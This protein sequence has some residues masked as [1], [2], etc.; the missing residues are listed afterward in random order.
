MQAAELKEVKHGNE[1]GLKRVTTSD[2]LIL[3][4][5]LE[6]MVWWMFGTLVVLNLCFACFILARRLGPQYYGAGRWARTRDLEVTLHRYCES[7]DPALLNGISGLSGWLL[8]KA[9][10]WLHENRH[11]INAARRAELLFATG[12]AGTYAARAYGRRSAQQVLL[13]AGLPVVVI[14]PSI[15]R[16]K[17]Y[18]RPRPCSVVRTHAVGELANLPGHAGMVFALAAMTDTSPEVRRQAVLALGRTGHPGVLPILWMELQNHQ[19]ESNNTAHVE[20]ALATF[21]PRA[22]S[23]F[24]PML[25]SHDA[26]VRE[27]AAQAIAR[28]GQRAVSAGSNADFPIEVADILKRSMMRD[29]SMKVRAHAIAAAPHLPRVTATNLLRQLLTDESEIVRAEAAFACARGD[30]LELIPDLIRSSQDP[31]WQVRTAAVAALVELGNDAEAALCAAFLASID[32]YACDELAEGIQRSGL[33]RRLVSAFSNGE[34]FAVCAETVFR[35]MI[36][37]GKTCALDA[38]AG[39]GGPDRKIRQLLKCAPESVYL[40]GVEMRDLQ[41][42]DPRATEQIRMV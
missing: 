7:A 34:P 4:L 19:R 21:E 15:Q 40:P 28:V 26:N 17:R 30:L 24:L 25:S 6:L 41:T 23:A 29:A 18:L 33:L 10:T 12:L 37:L 38:Y 11:R 13:R 20:W 42:L 31:K 2:M 39:R 22:L 1:N 8:T 36:F 27:K 5:E 35:K 32:P 16:A 14:Q 3:G 9:E